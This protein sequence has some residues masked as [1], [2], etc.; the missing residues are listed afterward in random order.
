MKVTRVTNAGCPQ[1]RGFG[2]INSLG[3]FG[4]ESYRMVLRECT[5]VR[6]RAEV[7][8]T[9]DA[10]TIA[11]APATGMAAEDA[12]LVK[13]AS[14]IISDMCQ[15]DRWRMCIPAHPDDSDLVLGSLV[16][17]FREQAADLT[18][19]IKRL[20]WISGNATS[21]S[22]GYEADGYPS[23]DIIRSTHGRVLLV[24]TTLPVVPRTEADWLGAALD[25]AIAAEADTAS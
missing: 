3:D 13:K 17:R 1:C 7:E 16:R 6:Y 21:V 2:L 18:R 22:D 23:R 11:E 5:C 8:P 4:S 14:K 9:M 25:L 20:D 19:A 24:N 12:D 10:E 15:G